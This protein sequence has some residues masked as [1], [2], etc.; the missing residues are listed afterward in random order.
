MATNIRLDPRHPRAMAS[1]LS[2]EVRAE[3]ASKDDVARSPSFETP[4]CGSSG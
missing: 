3:R 1:P 4:L 2:L